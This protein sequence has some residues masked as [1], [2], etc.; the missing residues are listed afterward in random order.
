MHKNQKN[1]ATCKVY[2]ERIRKSPK[3]TQKNV[4]ETSKSAATPNNS[5]TK[6][7]AA[8][9]LFYG[10]K[11]VVTKKS[12]FLHFLLAFACKTRPRS[13]RSKKHRTRTKKS[14]FGRFLQKMVKK[15]IFLENALKT[16]K[17]FF[18]L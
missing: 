4:T 7:A 3:K 13:M 8:F 12:A 9:F 2:P 16:Q 11:N 17:K 18:S 1:V 15:V 6:K 14:G 5:L 10:Q